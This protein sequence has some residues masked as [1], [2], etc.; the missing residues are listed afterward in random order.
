VYLPLVAK[1]SSPNLWQLVGFQQESVQDI[2][3]ESGGRPSIYAAVETPQGLYRSRD[4]GRTWQQIA[5]GLQP[6]ARVT[7]V[8]VSPASP[9][10]IYATAASYP[11]FYLSS[12]SG[13]DWT[14]GGDIPL[15]PKLLA[16]H[17]TISAR[18]FVGVGAWDVW[19]GGGQLYVSEDGGLTWTQAIA[20]QVLA[21]S[22]AASAQDPSLVYVGGTGLYRSQDGGRHFALLGG[23]LAE[24]Q[25]EAVA[26]DPF[27]PLIG[28]VHTDTAVFRSNDGGNSWSQWGSKP[29]QGSQKLLIS[30]RTP[31]LQYAASRDCAGVYLSRDQGLHWEPVNG[32][33]GNLCV[34]DLEATSDFARLYAATSKGLWT[35]DLSSGVIQ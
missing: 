12:T 15:I 20:K 33:L 4:T 3:L 17:P 30:N 22:V 34:T 10:E 2:S 26:I 23:A 31:S 5:T 27:D 35:L 6:G 1:A 32:G 29:P 8:A 28:F 14:V 7:H 19:G 13:D 11:R 18:L 25:V 16:L 9:S 21:A 24:A